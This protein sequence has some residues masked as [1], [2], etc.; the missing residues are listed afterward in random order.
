M[1]LSTG[2]YGIIEMVI[3]EN[4]EAAVGISILSCGEPQIL[5]SLIRATI[6]S[7]I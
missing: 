3:A 4:V 7:E 1:M 2:A 5:L 6:F